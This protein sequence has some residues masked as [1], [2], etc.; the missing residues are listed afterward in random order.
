MKTKK[1]FLATMLSISLLAASCGGGGTTEAT[2]AV[3][4]APAGAGQSSCSR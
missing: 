2:S 1:T 4:E 3:A